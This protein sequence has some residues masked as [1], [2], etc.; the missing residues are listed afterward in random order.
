MKLKT[1]VNISF[2][3]VI[4]LP[5]LM[6][7][8]TFSG[9]FFL[10]RARIEAAYGMP[11]GQMPPEMRQ[12]LFYVIVLMAIVLF[13]TGVMLSLWIYKSVT[14]PL[15][16]LG[17]A[18]HKIRDGEL[19]FLIEEE[20]PEEV[21]T[22][23]R[24]FEQMRGRLKEASEEKIRNDNEN[25]ELISNI[26]HDLRTPIAAIK[27]YVEGILDGVA[28]TPEK[29]DHYLRTIYNKTNEMDR[30][31]GEL[32]LYSRIDTNRMPYAF[33]AI[34]VRRFFDDAAEDISLELS[35]RQVAFEYQNEVPE[36]VQF[37]ADGEQI[38][39]VVSNIISNSLKYMDKPEKRMEMHVREAGDFI[40]VSIKDNGAGI[41]KKDLASIFNRFYRADPSRHPSQGG[42][43]IGLSIVKKIVEDHGGRVWAQSEIGEETTI[44]LEFR[45]YITGNPAAPA[46]ADKQETE[47]GKKASASRASSAKRYRRTRTGK[48]PVKK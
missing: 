42:S 23:C 35:G 6:M 13:I 11:L 32:T 16:K 17:A 19:D 9:A 5:L 40:E 1:R 12:L 2:L 7:G 29:M 37:I 24:D 34:S 33:A 28:D 48:Q 4:M 44:F 22:L 15:K 31:I 10:F 27:G 38:A 14:E 3:I 26:S 8:M 36:D 39:R 41:A 45:K 46:I 30:L 47:A 21:R 25:K 43:G 18:T 20:G